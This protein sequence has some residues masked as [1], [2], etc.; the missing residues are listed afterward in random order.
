MIEFYSNAVVSNIGTYVFKFNLFQF[1]AL[2]TTITVTSGLT[3]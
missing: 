2:Q 1:F 3:S